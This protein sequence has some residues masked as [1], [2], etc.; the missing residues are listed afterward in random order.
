MGCPVGSGKIGIAFCAGVNGPVAAEEMGV[1]I[2]TSPISM[3]IDYSKTTR[4]K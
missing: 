1:K 4:L 3:L 2:K